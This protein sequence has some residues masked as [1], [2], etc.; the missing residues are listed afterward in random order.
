MQN[1]VYT[2]NPKHVADVVVINNDDTSFSFVHPDSV[3]LAKKVV[4]I[5]P[6]DL[7]EKPK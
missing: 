4:W 2:L 5:F 6:H 1:N 7:R 3:E